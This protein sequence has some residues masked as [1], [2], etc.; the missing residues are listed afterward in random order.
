[1][2]NGQPTQPDVRDRRSS[3]GKRL[4]AV[5]ASIALAALLLGACGSSGPTASSPDGTNADNSSADNLSANVAKAEKFSQCMRAHGVGAFPDPD[6][7]GQLTIDG[8]ANGTSLNPNTPSFRQALNECKDLEP[9]GFMG[10]ARTPVQQAAALKFAQCMRDNGITNFPDPTPNGP[11]INVSGAHSIPGFQAAQQ[12]C[13]A[14]Y[15][16][17]LGLPGR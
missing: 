17:Q 2:T 16:G 10:S 3:S 9:P 7:S 11:I 6:S 4:L 12:K 8:I 14:I 15:A 13:S 5:L 1:M